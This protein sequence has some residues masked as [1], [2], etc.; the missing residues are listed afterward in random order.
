M[1]ARSL[2]EPPLELSEWPAGHQHIKGPAAEVTGQVEV[3]QQ[4]LG[5]YEV[6]CHRIET[7]GV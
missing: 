6:P 1:E 4:G 5:N 2:V 3:R 7:R